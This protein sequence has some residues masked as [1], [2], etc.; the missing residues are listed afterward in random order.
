MT[1]HRSRSALVPGIALAAVS[2]IAVAGALGCAAADG[3][4][5]EPGRRND[6]GAGARDAGAAS[7]AAGLP[8]GDAGTGAFA[9]E[10][11]A[12]SGAGCFDFVDTDGDG[13]LDCDDLECSSTPVCCVGSSSAACCRDSTAETLAYA[14]CTGTGTD[15]LLTCTPGVTVFGSPSPEL[16]EG[17]LVPNGGDRFDSGIVLA[18]EVDPRV[19]RL[20]IEATIAAGEGCESCLDSVAIGLT[21]AQAL[22]SS[23]LVDA[24]LALMVSTASG[25]V[26]LLVGGAVSRAMALD[27]VRELVGAD[28]LAPLIYRLETTTE[29]DARVLVA[30]SAEA[31][32]VSLFADVPYAPRGP[33]RV[34]AWGRSANRGPSDPPPARI[35][36]ISV[37]ERI[38]DAPASL[39]RGGE[40]ILPDSLD[41]WWESGE[42]ALA[43]SVFAYDDALGER[44][45]RMAFVY[46]GRIHVAAG[47]EGGRFRALADPRVPENA[48]LAPGGAEWMGGGIGD[49]VLVRSADTRWHLWFTAI[50]ADGTR[51]IAR[52]DAAAPDQLVFGEPVQVLVPDELSGAIGWD[53]PSVVGVTLGGVPRAF[54]AA[55]RWSAG[56]SGEETAI[57]L[58]E[59]TD[60]SAAP[61]PADVTIFDPAAGEVRGDS[62]VVRRA[63]GV[64]SDFDADEVAAPALVVYG[65]VLRLY[66]AGR[67]GTRWSI[68]VMV[69]QDGQHW[70][71]ASDGRAVLSG[72]GAGFDALSVSD[73]AP[74]VEDG[75]LRLYHTGS[76]GVLASIGLA[77]HAIPSEGDAP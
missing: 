68:G 42:R 40:P 20:E 9:G 52:A 49:P 54:L 29:G 45:A 56:A 69:S 5:D 51:S 77:R 43:P 12:P 34:V 15:A 10:N 60:A 55:R 70:R 36:R 14:G 3:A 59:L 44:R 24:D 4:G 33:A 17:A 50:A 21:R 25:E 46:Q 66:Y 26:R 35:T 38:C 1:L 28:A 13:S 8:A 16:R 67:R 7:D 63:T 62:D 65:G 71:E 64:P 47:I 2:V 30:A 41:A 75:E 22:G 32:A 48:I 61:I 39:A 58:F 57:V 18:S 76:D 23:T 37:S 72:S 31:T 11:D 6:G 73:P 19:S 74:L 27:G 53:G